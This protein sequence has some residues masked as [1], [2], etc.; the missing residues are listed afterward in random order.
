MSLKNTE[1]KELSTVHI[2]A[3]SMTDLEVK[4]EEAMYQT[5][6]YFTKMMLERGL[7]SEDEYRKIEAEF[8]EKYHPVIG[9]LYSNLTNV[10]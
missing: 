2:S 10:A 1:K 9:E 3:T 6:M 4:M 7:I 5:T 8:L